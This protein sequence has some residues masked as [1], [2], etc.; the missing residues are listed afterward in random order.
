[1]GF[2]LTD[3][4]KRPFAVKNQDGGIGGGEGSPRKKTERT[5]GNP[6]NAGAQAKYRGPDKGQETVGRDEGVI[7]FVPRG[8]A[9]PCWPPG[10]LMNQPY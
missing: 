8:L 1:M 5:F 6:V 2:M 10:H 9:S 4:A 3:G 7:T